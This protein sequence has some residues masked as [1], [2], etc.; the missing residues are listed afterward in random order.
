MTALSVI[1]GVLR[2]KETSYQ[3]SQ[4]TSAKPVTVRRE[5][6]INYVS[7]KPVLPLL[8]VVLIMFLIGLATKDKQEDAAFVLFA[9]SAGL[10]FYCYKRVTKRLSQNK[11][12]THT[13]M[14]GIS[15]YLANGDSELF[16][17][18]KKETIMEV[19]QGIH[20]AM[21]GKTGNLVDLKHSQIQITDANN[22]TIGSI[23]T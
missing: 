12:N 13:T 10:L 23:D 9:A 4:M 1:D 2:Y 11:E 5:R 20:E 8:G 3:I 14:F 22:V 16:I 18:S 17:S 6:K 15:L 7:L 19:Y 21:K